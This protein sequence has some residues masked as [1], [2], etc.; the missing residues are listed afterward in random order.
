MP[1][2]DIFRQDLD[3]QIHGVW[4]DAKPGVR[5]KIARWAN[6]KFREKIRQ[7][8]ERKKE[9][10]GALKISLEESTELVKEA[11]AH[12]VLLDWEGIAGS[13]GRPLAY[14]PEAALEW[15]RDPELADFYEWVQTEAEN[16]EHF[17]KAIAEAEVKNSQTS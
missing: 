12:T 2:I 7:L 5:F 10:L 16:R 13:D 6:V 15:F 8:V 3:K 9:E 11:A 4:I 17:R 1:T 14:S